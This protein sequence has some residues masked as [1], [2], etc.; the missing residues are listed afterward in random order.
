MFQVKWFVITQIDLSVKVL[1]K[2]LTI[3]SLS[4]FKV[5][6]Q[7]RYLTYFFMYVWLLIHLSYVNSKIFRKHFP[8]CQN[9]TILMLI[10]WFYWN[11]NFEISFSNQFLAL[12]FRSITFHPGK[13]FTQILT[14][15]RK[16]CLTCVSF[17]HS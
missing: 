12:V 14:P 4:T 7:Y 9:K 11:F 13:H 16:F 2:I 6:F 1:T 5:Y 10:N 17:D 8:C 3:I 15:T